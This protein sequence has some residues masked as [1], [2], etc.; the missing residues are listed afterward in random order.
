MLCLGSSP[1]VV[2]EDQSGKFAMMIEFV[3]VGIGLAM[4][5]LDD[6][7]HR[8]SLTFCFFDLVS[9]PGLGRVNLT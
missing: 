9:F 3:D 4:L 8:V 1:F 7:R 6:H 5:C 2:D